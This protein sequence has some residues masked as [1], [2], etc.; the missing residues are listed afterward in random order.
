MTDPSAGFLKRI[1]AWLPGSLQHE[2]RRLFFS[3][4]IR[5]KRFFTD[6][7]EYALLERYLSPGAWALDIG[8][9]VGHYAMRMSELVGASGRVI[10]FEPVPD[11]FA[12]LSANARLFAHR[13]VSLLNVAASERSAVVGMQIPVFSEGL[14]N[15]YQAHVTAD[16]TE[17]TVLS[18]AV[19][20]L[21]L[22]APVRLVKIDVEGHELPVLRGMRALLERDHPVLI[23]ETGSEETLAFLH[24]L[25][26]GT[27][28]L[29]GSSNVVCRHVGAPGTRHAPDRGTPAAVPSKS[30]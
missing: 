6:E 24:D 27:E 14:S 20:A 11:T 16:V 10:A 8:A 7:Q 12:L 5:R 4:Q 29:P 9:N 1:A 17:L 2:L 25:R 28:R 22:D 15:Y 13:N 3:R 26:Y 23:I 21:A 19:D 30:S 18:I